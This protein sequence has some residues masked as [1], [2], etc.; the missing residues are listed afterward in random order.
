MIKP[1]SQAPD[2]ELKTSPTETV[3]LS[4][5]RDRPVVL[6]F[7]PADFS[8]VC[9][10]QLSLY[11]NATPAFSQ[12]DAELLAISTDGVWCHQAFAAQ[13]EL[14]FPLVSDSWP[15]GG[16][17]QAYGVLDTENGI[18]GRALFVLDPNGIVTWSYL[19]PTEINPGADGILAALDAMNTGSTRT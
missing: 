2:F 7:Y 1:G 18:A 6:V 3:R 8:P 13:R 5:L 15:H 14:K 19:S 4:A 12:Y 11:Q 9:S 17:A 10:D 16:V